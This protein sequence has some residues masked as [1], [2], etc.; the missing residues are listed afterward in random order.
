M[1]SSCACGRAWASCAPASAATASRCVRLLA[2]FYPTCQARYH[3]T[4]LS[5]L[6]VI[7]SDRDALLTSSQGSCATVGQIP[8][9]AR[10]GRLAHTIL[11]DSTRTRRIRYP[12]R[13]PPRSP[14]HPDRPREDIHRAATGG[15]CE[16]MHRASG[17][18]RIVCVRLSVGSVENV[19]VTNGTDVRPTKTVFVTNG[20]NVRP[21]RFVCVTNGTAIHPDATVFVTNGTP[22]AAF[23]KVF[24]YNM[25]VLRALGFRG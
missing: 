8:R 19:F 17:Q 10:Q 12:R 2:T 14:G 1:M 6:H 16:F 22:Q 13:Q 20:T 24:V 9:A 23:E 11:P 5:V 21:E 7:E 25:E 3:N 4:E 18:G 15:R